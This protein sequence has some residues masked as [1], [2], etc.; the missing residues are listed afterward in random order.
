MTQT[1]TCRLPPPPP[2]GCECRAR[3]QSSWTC[4]SVR[5]GVSRFPA[6]PT[7]GT[8]GRVSAGHPVTRGRPLSRVC[9]WRGWVSQEAGVG[10]GQDGSWVSEPPS[11]LSCCLGLWLLLRELSPRCPLSRPPGSPIPQLQEGVCV[12][13]AQDQHG[14]GFLHLGAAMDKAVRGRG[15]AGLVC[16]A[17]GR[18]HG[19]QYEW[20][21]VWTSSWSPAY[22][23]GRVKTQGTFR[24]PK[25][26]GHKSSQFCPG[27]DRARGVRPRGWTERWGAWPRSECRGA[28]PQGRRERRGAQ[29]RAQVVF[30]TG[31]EAVA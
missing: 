25:R 8:L 2:R 10:E 18:V 26:K 27:A 12:P 28:R 16:Q 5:W 31:K 19:A 22:R 14:R 11:S 21:S 4:T 15:G 23:G 6:G 24:F 3:P 17:S 30:S 20:G 7:P 9:H 13:T 29:P 1:R